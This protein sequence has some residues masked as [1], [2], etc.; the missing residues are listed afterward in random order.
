MHSLYFVRIKEAKD[1]RDAIAKAITVLD[2]NQFAGDGGFFCSPKADWYVVGG[3]WSGFLTDITANGKRALDEIA[4][5][6]KADFPQLAYGIRGVVYGSA[7]DRTAHAEASRRADAIYATATGLPYIR[8]RYHE[9]GYPD[10]AQRVTPELLSA[11]RASPE[12]DAEVCLVGDNGAP[13]SEWLM[14]DLDDKDLLG[15]W[16]VVVD[17]HL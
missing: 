1:A 7:E 10:D 12:K 11:L 9:H 3:R 13:E 5:M 6:S 15:Y 16:L 4:A 17:Y 2:E 8:D 14:A